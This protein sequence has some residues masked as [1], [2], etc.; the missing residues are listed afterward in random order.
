MDKKGKKVLVVASVILVLITLFVMIRYGFNHKDVFTNIDQFKTLVVSYG[1]FSFLMFLFI[2]IIQ[3]VFFFIPGEVVQVAGG[4]IFG[5]YV[6]FLL[7]IIGAI[8]G[9]AIAFLI[10]RK[11][12]K[13][14][15][16]K[17]CGKNNLWLINRLDK[18]KDDK[19]KHRDPKKLIFILYLIP[20]VPKDLLAYICGVADISL[21]DFLIL[22]TFGRAPALFFSCMIGNQVSIRN[23]TEIITIS[24]AF[25]VVFGI[26]FLLTR[27]HISRIKREEE[28]EA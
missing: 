21:K 4:Y 15:L 2:Q 5:P 12:G 23:W 9:S 11:L 24:V 28:S 3:I 17:I 16:Q 1:N 27:K 18:S 26:L 22:S 19:K 20:G 8:I 25:L 6:S 7:C 13:P 14:F 10:T